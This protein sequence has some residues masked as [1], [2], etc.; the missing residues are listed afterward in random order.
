[1]TRSERLTRLGWILFLVGSVVFLVAAL[2]Q[3]DVVTAAGSMLFVLGVIAFLG[4]EAR[5][6]RSDEEGVGKPDSD[7]RHNELDARRGWRGRSARRALR[8]RP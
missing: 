6:R 5:S 3:G 8:R 7:T 4:A 2:L 1:M